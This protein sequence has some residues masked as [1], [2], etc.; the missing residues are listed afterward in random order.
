[1]N[2]LTD[3]EERFCQCI[4]EGR[5]QYESYLMAG[6]ANNTDR[7]IVDTN[8]SRLANDTKI[9]LRINELRER[10]TSSKVLSITQRKEILSEIGKTEK[11]A[12]HKVR[13]LH[14][15]NLMERVYDTN[16]NVDNRHINIYVSS[17]KAKD[18]TEKLLDV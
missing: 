11:Y 14:E 16:V 10:A 7:A 4:A 9:V 5:S 15:L 8:A 13:A 18:L 1:M 6:Y 12:G 2:R 17:D 3:K